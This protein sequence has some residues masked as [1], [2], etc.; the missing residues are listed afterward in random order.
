MTDLVDKDRGAT[1]VVDKVAFISV[2]VGPDALGRL[3]LE[4]ISVLL[5]V[6]PTLGLWPSLLDRL[7]FLS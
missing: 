5:P 2:D 6:F 3:H 4:D 7:H 1:L